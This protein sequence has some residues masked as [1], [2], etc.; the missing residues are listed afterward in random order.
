METLKEVVSEYKIDDNS[1]FTIVYNQQSD[2]KQVGHLLEDEKQQI[3]VNC[4]ARCLQ[5][6]VIEEFS[7]SAVAQ[8]L[9]A[10]KAVVNTSTIVPKLLKSYEKVK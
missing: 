5:L 8:G 2:F 10:P 4:A 7:I 9:A 3:N 6:C 1:I